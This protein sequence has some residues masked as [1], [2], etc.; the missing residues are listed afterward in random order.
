LTKLNVIRGQGKILKFLSAP[1]SELDEVVDSKLFTSCDDVGHRIWNCTDCP[2]RQKL[3]KDVVK[4]IERRH[5]SIRLPCHLC[6]AVANSR[7]QLKIH[8]KARHDIW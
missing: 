5:L 7:V 6:E 4:H 8:L 2:Y 3:R 1:F